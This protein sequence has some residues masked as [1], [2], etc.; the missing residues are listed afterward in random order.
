MRSPP[1][2]RAAHV[3]GGAGLAIGDNDGIWFMAASRLDRCRFPRPFD[4][5]KANGAALLARKAAGSGLVGY[6]LVQL[7]RTE[8]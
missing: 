7:T 2:S 6:P 1:Y 8:D 4:T 3:E 5:I